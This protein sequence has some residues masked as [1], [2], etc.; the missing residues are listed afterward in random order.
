MTGNY[1][2][3]VVIESIEVTLLKEVVVFVCH[4]YFVHSEF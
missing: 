4:T 3:T 1:I 2:L